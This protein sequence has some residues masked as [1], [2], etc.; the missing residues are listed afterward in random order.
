MKSV[1]HRTDWDRGVAA[2]EMA[3]VPNTWTAGRMVS[4]MV[5][6]TGYADKEPSQLVL[7]WGYG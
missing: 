6:K 7:G 2:L 4:V 5:G 3:A 1:G